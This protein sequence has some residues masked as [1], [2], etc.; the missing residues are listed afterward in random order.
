MKSLN[1]IFRTIW[2][3][4]LGVW[5]AVSEITKSRGKRSASSL[6]R[7]VQI[8]RRG[9]AID[10]TAPRTRLRP[11]LFAVACC[12]AFDALA[13]PIGGAV[14]NGQAIFNTSGNTLTVTNTP[15]TIINWQG[16]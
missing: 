13:N 16:F 6:I 2:S 3:E 5:I 12:F 10:C 14:V 8:E 4:A 1:H 11:I 15:G 7:E 9:S